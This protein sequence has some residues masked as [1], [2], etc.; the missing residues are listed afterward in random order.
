MRPPTGAAAR[1][2]AVVLLALASAAWPLASGSVQAHEGHEHADQ[3]AAEAGALASPR[4]VA[5]TEKYQFVG[6]VEGEVL[7]V[8]LDRAADN[9]PITGA[10][11]DVSLDG[12]S[13]KAEPVGNGT[14]EI[15]APALKRPGQIEV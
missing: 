15:T 11:I 6:I 10:T 9:G 3:P 2:L 7:V 1:I 5:T 4:V 8:Y 12:Q 14:Y 13:F